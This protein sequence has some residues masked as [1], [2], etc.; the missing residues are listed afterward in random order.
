MQDTFSPR[1]S[2]RCLIPANS[3]SACVL[4]QLVAAEQPVG[5]ALPNE[6]PALDGLEVEHLG[7]LLTAPERGRCLALGCLVRPLDLVGDKAPGIAWRTHAEHGA[8]MPH[9]GASPVVSGVLRWPGGRFHLTECL[10]LAS[11]HRRTRL[12]GWLQ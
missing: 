9:Q 8:V 3:K 2:S 1:K 4:D 11:S 6:A 7:E 5:V 12:V 10:L